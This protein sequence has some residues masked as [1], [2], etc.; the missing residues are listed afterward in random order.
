MTPPETAVPDHEIAFFRPGPDD[1]LLPQDMARSLWS[2]DQMH[3]VAVSAALGRAGERALAEAGRDDLVPARFTVDLFR[4]ARMDP[5]RLRTTVVRESARLCL[6]DVGLEQDGSDGPVLVAR[7]SLLALKPSATPP[8]DV[9]APATGPDVPPLDVVPETDSSRVP[10]F[11]S[12]EA[13]WTQDFG[14]HQNGGRKQAW[15][16]IPTAVAGELSSAFVAAAAVADSASMVTNWG[17]AGVEFINTDITLSLARLPVSR[18]I[19]L[20]ASDRVEH[21]GVAVGTVVLF[22]RQGRLGSC[23]VTSLANAKRTV[24]FEDV[25]FTREGP[26]ASPPGV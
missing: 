5:C 21:D 14:Q 9:W 18:E 26:R 17:S 22:D 20:A 1:V 16:T 25:T 3:G 8:G 13:G 15:Q 4:P 24:D 11:W 23:T 2:A 10:F 12:E 19:G 6:V 7:A